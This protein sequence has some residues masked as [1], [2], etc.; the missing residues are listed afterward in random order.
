MAPVAGA[1]VRKGPDVDFKGARTVGVVRQPQAVGRDDAAAHVEALGSSGVTLCVPSS[2][3]I[4]SSRVG[5]ASLNTTPV[6][7]GVIPE[8]NWPLL[9]VVSRSAAPVP[10]AACHQRLNWPPRFELKMIRR[11]SGVHTGNQ[12]WPGSSVRRVSVA[13][14]RSQIQRSCS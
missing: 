7:S 6:P 2:A 1:D 3:T 8:A 5:V 14:R 4:R 9:L 11:L 12:S 10:S 13:R